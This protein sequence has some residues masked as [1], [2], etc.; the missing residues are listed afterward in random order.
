M[1]RYILFTTLLFPLMLLA[2]SPKDKGLESIN[3]MSAETHIGFLANDALEGR[4]AGKRGSKI[5]SEY[6]KAF[7]RENGISSFGESYYQ[8][9]E[10]YSRERQK[11][12]RFSVHP[13]SIIKYKKEKAH[14]ML[15]MRN[16][17]GFIEGENKNEYVV[18]GAHFDHL[19]IDE[20]LVNDKIYNGA[21]DNASGV[22]AV[23]Q[24]ARAFIKSGVKPK[25]SIIFAFWD[26]E[27]LGLL[28]SEFFLLN[29]PELSQIKGY[30]NFDMI[31]RNSDES[32]PKQVTYFYTESHP[33]FGQ[34]LKEDIQKYDI[35]LSPDYVAWEK[36]VSG[37]DNASF[38][39]R[40][41]PILWYHTGGNPDYH[42]PSDHTDKINWN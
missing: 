35:E 18:I 14:R 26:G 6:I 39:R 2:Q 11:K 40:G 8:P 33:A 41:I 21:D 13:D 1:K 30:L 23:L 19:G 36:P 10:A 17:L 34:W 24:I 37:S 22:S 4:E 20:T 27:E 32:K 15:E 12:M 5:A 9:F 28:G 42:Q 31:G 16:V 3:L 7:L 25:R 38:A 29:F